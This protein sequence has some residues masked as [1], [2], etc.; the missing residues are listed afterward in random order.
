M[1]QNDLNIN[2]DTEFRSGERVMV[3]RLSFDPA[4]EAT[5]YENQ[6]SVMDG[7]LRVQ[8]ADDSIDSVSMRKVEKI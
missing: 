2:P 5:V 7:W 8:F 3:K 6:D 1:E 4:V